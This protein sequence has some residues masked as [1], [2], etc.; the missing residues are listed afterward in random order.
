M[1]LRRALGLVVAAVAATATIATT[2]LRWALG[3]VARCK[4]ASRGVAAGR[5]TALTAS[6]ATTTAATT[7]TVAAT[8]TASVGSAFALWALAFTHTLQHFCAGGASGSLH[9]VAAWWLTSATPNGLAT[10]GDGLG[11]FTGLGHE[12]FNDLHGNVLLGEALDGLHEAFFV[13]AN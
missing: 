13:Q 10:H 5:M 2:A 8:A 1:T 12:A 6:I 4:F 3:R 11:F 9:H 7:T